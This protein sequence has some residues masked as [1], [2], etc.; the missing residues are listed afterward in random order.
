MARTKKTPKGPGQGRPGIARKYAKEGQRPAKPQTDE[1]Q[2]LKTAMQSLRAPQDDHHTQDTQ[3]LDIDFSAALAEPQKPENPNSPLVDNNIY[4]YNNDISRQVLIERENINLVD[5]NNPQKTNHRKTN[6]NKDDKVLIP[7]IIDD[8]PP[9]ETFDLKSQLT[10][11]ELNFIEF[12]LTG[13]YT[14][15]KAMIAAGYN[16][17]HQDTL[18]KMSRKII[19]RYE[20]QAGD[21]RKIMRAMGYGEVKVIEMMIEAAT[22]FK[23]ETVRQ[24]ARETLGKWLGIQTEVI[25]GTEGITIV[26]RGTKSATSPEQPQ[27]TAPPAPTIKTRMIK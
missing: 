15:E 9:N 11:K 13:N 3:D 12:Y 24:K 18:Y 21:H 2:D 7:E 20:S 14:I 5:S 4:I 19:Q 27:P 16:G 17:Y 1:D 6:K 25:D 8:N 26:I 23:S 10:L 22:K